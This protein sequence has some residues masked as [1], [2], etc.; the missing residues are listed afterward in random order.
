MNKL[1][2]KEMSIFDINES[3][4]YN[5]SPFKDGI[6]KINSYRGKKHIL[7]KDIILYELVLRIGDKFY[8]E[9]IELPIETRTSRQFRYIAAYLKRISKQLESVKR[10]ES[11]VQ[12]DNTK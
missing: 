8:K 1:K 6:I 10:Y 2:G 11:R 4:W 3:P 12:N 7:G 9:R 5:N